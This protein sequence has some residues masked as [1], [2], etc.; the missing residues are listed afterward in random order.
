MT[1]TSS[2]APL[3]E[4]HALSKAFDGK[5]IIADLELTINHGEFLTI[6]GPPAVA[7]PRCCA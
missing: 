7:K 1:E 4:L 5:T 6:L 3:V 2:R